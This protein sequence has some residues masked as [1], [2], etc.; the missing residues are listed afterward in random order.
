[1]CQSPCLKESFCCY[2]VICI[3]FCMHC[4]VFGCYSCGHLNSQ[5]QYTRCK[6]VLPVSLSWFW[7]VLNTLKMRQTSPTTTLQAKPAGGGKPDAATVFGYTPPP[8]IQLGRDVYKFLQRL[9]LSI[10][11]KHPRRDLSNGF[12]VAEILSRFF[13]VSVKGRVV[14]QAIRWCWSY[15][16]PV[17][18]L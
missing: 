14:L 3:S 9:D 5:S 18:L 11:V 10:P 2:F 8:E 13:P 1:M 6:F 7:L 16:T 15:C 12:V 17:A 4:T